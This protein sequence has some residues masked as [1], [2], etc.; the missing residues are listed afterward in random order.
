MRFWT[1]KR[2]HSSVDLHEGSIRLTINVRPSNWGLLKVEDVQFLLH[3]TAQHF[4]R[5]FQ[6]PFSAKI[7][8][9]CD[10][11]STFGS[12]TR[13]IFTRN[14]VMILPTTRCWS[15]SLVFAHEL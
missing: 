15:W 3:N 14:H 13:I 1:S 6:A 9:L 4:V 10:P 2:A 8:V 12:I 7:H 11:G 5:F